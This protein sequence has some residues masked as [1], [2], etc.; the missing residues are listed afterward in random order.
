MLSVLIKAGTDGKAL[1]RTLAALVPAIAAGVLGDAIIVSLEASSEIDAVADAA[2]CHVLKGG[3]ASM[4]KTALAQLRGD[5]VLFLPAGC[6]LETGWWEDA[7]NFMHIADETAQAAFAY[8]SN[9]RG[10]SAV[11]VRLQAVLAGLT[12]KPLAAQGRILRRKSAEQAAVTDAVPPRCQGALVI[13]R[14]RAFSN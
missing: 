5:F 10:F 11:I 13:L 2:G 3:D 7:E 8:A 12:G 14:A 6:V 9:A 1:A 4:L